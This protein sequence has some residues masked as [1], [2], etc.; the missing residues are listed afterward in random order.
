MFKYV[1]A[2]VVFREIP[3]EITLAISISN[4]PNNCEGCHSPHL[5]DDIGEPLNIEALH[6]MLFEN[7]GITCIC[8]M[9]GD[10]DIEYLGT[11]CKYI[12]D[13]FLEIKTAWYSGRSK[14]N[15]LLLENLDYWKTGPYMK[16]KGGLDN[17]NTNQRLY[18]ITNNKTEDIT[19][20]FWKN[21]TKD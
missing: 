16:E 19:F 7:K 14:I 1:E 11:L 9:G 10:F 12:K 4:C 2:Q 21:E 6:T 15:N 8:F 20:K 3:D 17:P 13:N 5:K 18:K